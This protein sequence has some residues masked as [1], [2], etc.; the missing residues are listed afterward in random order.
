M[1]ENDKHVC[2]RSCMCVR[3]YCNCYYMLVVEKFSMLL[4]TLLSRLCCIYLNLFYPFFPTAYNFC[5]VNENYEILLH[6]CTLQLGCSN[7]LLETGTLTI[8]STFVETVRHLFNKSFVLSRVRS[9]ACRQ[10]A[11]NLRGTFNALL[12]SRPRSWL[13]AE[14]LLSIASASVILPF[15]SVASC[16]RG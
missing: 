2:V 12:S 5:L 9:Q 6:T 3:V 7:C 1:L 14:L 16:I 11:M 15:R 13:P 10:L 4:F 8:P